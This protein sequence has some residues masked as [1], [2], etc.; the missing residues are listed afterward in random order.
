MNL[1]QTNTVATIN[2]ALL[3]LDGKTID[4]GEQLAYLHGH[5]HLLTGMEKALEG[6]GVGQQVEVEISPDDAF[7]AYVE[8][9]EPIRIHRRE[10][11]ADFNRLEQGAAIP[12]KTPDGNETFLYVKHRQGSYATLTRN[13]PLAGV[14]FMFNASITAVRTA[15]PEEI[16]RQMAFGTNGDQKP[17]SCACC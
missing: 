16:E 17:S 10:F 5:E 14:S 12:I 13:H 15:L 7:G 8:E 6:K 2:Y 11:G 3:T 9:A 1:I 4:A